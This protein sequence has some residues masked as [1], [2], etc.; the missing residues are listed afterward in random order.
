MRPYGYKRKGKCT[1]QG[2]G[3]H[4]I[5]ANETIHDQ[6]HDPGRKKR[7]RRQAKKEIKNEER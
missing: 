6:V 4:C 3:T 7:A 1:V 2:H 5:V